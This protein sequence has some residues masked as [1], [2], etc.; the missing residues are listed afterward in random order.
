MARRPRGGRGG[1]TTQL[2][3]SRGQFTSNAGVGWEG[4]SDVQLGIWQMSDDIQDAA[5]QTMENLAIEAEDYM[6][7]NASWNDRTGAARDGLQA[8]AVHNGMD[9]TL[10]LSHGSSIFYGLWLELG[11]FAIVQPTYVIYG[12]KVMD[13]LRQVLARSQ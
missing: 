7:E 3:N 2:R 4:I 5:R 12:A 8:I 10:W 6:K 9:S 13:E 1:D 11:P